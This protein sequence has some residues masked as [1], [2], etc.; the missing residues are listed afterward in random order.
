MDRFFSQDLME[1]IKRHEGFRQY[2]Y[3]CTSGKLTIGY[4]HNLDDRGI[5]SSIARELLKEDI[6]IAT[7]DCFVLFSDFHLLS[8]NV[9]MALIDMSFQLGLNRLKKFK[10]MIKFIGKNNFIKASREAKDSKWFRQSGDRGKE[11]V[12]LLKK[13]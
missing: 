1:M 13:G 7:K 2:V 4:G 6:G 3:K 9:K 5:S 10:K 12:K 8:N 11:I